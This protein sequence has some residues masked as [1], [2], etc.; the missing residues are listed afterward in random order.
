MVNHIYLLDI[1]YYI[2]DIMDSSKK[3]VS[4]YEIAQKAL[5]LNVAPEVKLG[6]HI[7]GEFL[8]CESIPNKTDELQKVMEKAAKMMDAHIVK[9]VFH[10]FNPYGLSGVIVIAESHFA[11]HTWPEYRC[12]AVDLFSCSEL[13]V[14]KA[15]EFLKNSFGAKELDILRI[16]RGTRVSF[17]KKKI[18]PS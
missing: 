18:S 8:N 7:L 9:S 13:H 2:A 10:E 6:V 5:N 16:P 3:G 1:Q 11:I 17:G 12:A 15:F 14:E 4:Y